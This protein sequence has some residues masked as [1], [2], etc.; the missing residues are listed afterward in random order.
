VATETAQTETPPDETLAQM[1]ALV[2]TDPA[3]LATVAA[4]HMTPI[5]ARQQVEE[6]P[7]R[8]PASPIEIPD[9][10]LIHRI[11]PIEDALVERR[12]RSNRYRAPF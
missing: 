4:Y 2:S 11:V 9:V 7:T 1:I 12:N 8:E 5:I 10:G 6:P 3:E